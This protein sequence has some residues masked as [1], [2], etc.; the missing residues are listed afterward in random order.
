M[1]AARYGV[2]VY[3]LSF[4]IVVFFPGAVQGRG[5]VQDRDQVPSLARKTG[6]PAGLVRVRALDPSALLGKEVLSP[7][8]HD[9]HLQGRVQDRKARSKSVF[10][11]IIQFNCYTYYSMSRS[12]AKGHFLYCPV[13]S[14]VFMKLEF[15]GLTP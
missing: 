15:I 12:A 7:N 9:S 8:H 5:L 6:L 11:G 2:D 13:V 10:L 14:P 1:R 3:I 4:N